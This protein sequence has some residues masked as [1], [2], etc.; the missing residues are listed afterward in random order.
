[1]PFQI[2][3]LTNSIA[4]L[5]TAIRTRQ[6]TCVG[7]AQACLDQIHKNDKQGLILNAISDLSSTALEEAKALDREI[8][9][10]GTRGPLHGIPCV[11]KEEIAVKGCAWTGGSIAFGT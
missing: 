3:L 4:E 10:K 2:D 11:I 8:E 7:L 9:T 1:M 6:L 5:S